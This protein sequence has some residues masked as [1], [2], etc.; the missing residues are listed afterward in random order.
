[1][2][3]PVALMGVVA[4]NLMIGNVDDSPL[5]FHVQTIMDAE[6]HF[7]KPKGSF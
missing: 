1:M 3:K 5:P 6:F 7:L 2:S 4:E